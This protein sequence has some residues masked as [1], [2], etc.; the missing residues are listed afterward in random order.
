MFVRLGVVKKGNVIAT[1]N[2]EK[3]R[4]PQRKVKGREK[5]KAIFQNELASEQIK[6]GY[7][8]VETSLFKANYIF[9]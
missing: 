9:L 2:I 7:V 6:K 8:C 3:R 1:F 5:A 4:K